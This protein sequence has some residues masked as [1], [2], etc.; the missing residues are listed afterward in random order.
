MVSLQ[1][2]S[3]LLSFTNQHVMKLELGVPIRVSKKN[4][5]TWAIMKGCLVGDKEENESYYNLLSSC[6]SS[7]HLFLK[8]GNRCENF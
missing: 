3:A 1:N 5:I 8:G 4:A 6:L 7:L 2:I